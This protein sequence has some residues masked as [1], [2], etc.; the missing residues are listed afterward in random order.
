MR[1][2]SDR[3]ETVLRRE[4]MRMEMIEKQKQEASIGRVLQ[5]NAGWVALALLG[6]I[7][8]SWQLYKRW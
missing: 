7:L 1:A 5:R 4:V 8:A 2:D 3:R 6:A